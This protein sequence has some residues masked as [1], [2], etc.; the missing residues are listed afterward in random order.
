MILGRTTCWADSGIEYEA[1]ERHAEELMKE[2]CW[3][4]ESKPVAS[5]A[6]REVA[7]GHDEKPRGKKKGTKD[8]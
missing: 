1:D 2:L 8:R 5:P 4:E 3:G 6:V 7:R